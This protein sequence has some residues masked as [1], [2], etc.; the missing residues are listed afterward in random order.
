MVVVVRGHSDEEVEEGGL[1]CAVVACR[2]HPVHIQDG[3]GSPSGD[4]SLGVQDVGSK[5]H[6]EGAVVVCAWDWEVPTRLG[7]EGSRNQV[8]RTW[9]VGGGQRECSQ[10]IP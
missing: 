2:K 5:D 6:S 4:R 10:G 8:G 1:P 3:V 9:E 7:E